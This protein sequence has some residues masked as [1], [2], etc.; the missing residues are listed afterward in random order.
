[1]ATGLTPREIEVMQLVATGLTNSQIA[2]ELCI[3]EQTVK[4]H[5][6]SVLDKLQ[7]DDRTQA[8]IYVLYHGVI[9]LKIA[10]AAMLASKTRG[11]VEL[12]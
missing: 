8:T 3:S 7:L 6:T 2:R 4:N 5:M 1:M 12:H 11:K 9:D 10:Y